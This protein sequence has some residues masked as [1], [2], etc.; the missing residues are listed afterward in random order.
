M[1]DSMA[2][3]NMEVLELVDSTVKQ[4]DKEDMEG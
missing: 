4:V 1:E 2:A 3:V